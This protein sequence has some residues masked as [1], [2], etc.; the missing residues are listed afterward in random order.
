MIQRG[1][2]NAFLI[3]IGR[4]SND[5]R[6]ANFD[7][8]M[9][10]KYEYLGVINDPKEMAKLLRSVNY[11]LATYARDCFSQ[12]YLEA[13]LCGVKLYKPHMSGGLP[14]MLELLDEKGKD[15]FS[16]KRMVDEYIEYFETL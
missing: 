11:L 6:N 5:I 9:N 16:S 10:E 13:L 2:P 3:I 15:Y 4:F 7:F 12:T 14:E 1:N 8:F